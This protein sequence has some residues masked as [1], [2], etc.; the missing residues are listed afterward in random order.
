MQNLEIMM[1]IWFES[2]VQYFKTD[3]NGY[4]KK[5]TENYMV[6]GV[7]FTDVEA[8][9]IGQMQTMVKGDFAV[10]D[11]KKSRVGEIFA[12]EN[13]EWWFKA[14]VNLVTIDEEKG[15]EKKVRTYYLVMADDIQ[16]ALTRL[17]E[18]LQGLVIPYVVSS[19]TLSTIVDV[20]PYDPSEVKLPDNFRA[21]TDEEKIEAQVENGSDV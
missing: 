10:T 3:E 5:V 12:Y 8:R 21:L 4:E 9:M 16:E 20:F 17:D 1:Q 6:D 2:K 15:K 19:I 14:T 18:S 7:S 11:I 13:G